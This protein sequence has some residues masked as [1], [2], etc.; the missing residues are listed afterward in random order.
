MEII[1]LITLIMY[2]IHESVYKEPTYFIRIMRKKYGGRSSIE[3]KEDEISK[4]NKLFYP[5]EKLSDFGKQAIL[6]EIKLREERNLAE[7]TS[8]QQYH[9]IK[10]MEQD[11]EDLKKKTDFLSSDLN[12]TSDEMK[13][14]RKVAIDAG[15]HTRKLSAKMNE[16]LRKYMSQK[17]I[18]KF[19]TAY[20]KKQKDTHKDHS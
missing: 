16:T 8:S 13:E 6:A 2:I 4:I 1:F 19:L 5:Q 14:W 10:S 17:E 12:Q 15:K 18:D 3:I 7:L 9:K 11:I 20:R